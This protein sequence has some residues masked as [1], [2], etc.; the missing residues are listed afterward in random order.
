MASSWAPSL[1]SASCYCLFFGDL[2]FLA[3]SVGLL[4][5][6]MGVV[7]WEEAFVVNHLPQI[8]FYNKLAASRSFHV[9]ALQIYILTPVSTC[10][11]PLR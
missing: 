11:R 2:D 1:A 4:Y 8:P 7:G 9:A 3:V 5:T 6:S 10:F